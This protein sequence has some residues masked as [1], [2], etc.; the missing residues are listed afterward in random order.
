MATT[1]SDILKSVNAYT[2]LESALPTGTELT[3]RIDYANQA[4]RDAGDAYNFPQFNAIYRPSVSSAASIS[5]PSNFKEF[6]GAPQVMESDGSYIQFPQIEPKDLYTQSASGKYCYV[7]GNPMEGYTAVF[8]NLS[9]GASLSIPYQRQ[10]SGF[11]T[12]T[13]VSELPSTEYVKQAIIAYVLEAR[14]DDR[15]EGERGKANALLRNMIGR[16][17]M[18]RKSGG[19]NL[20]PKSNLYSIGS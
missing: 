3:T 1:L 12:L 18:N 16:F 5:L 14:G 10:P 8:N 13:D 20:T 15:S 9:A 7:L 4:V 17:G 11:A 19:Y 2:D 6:S